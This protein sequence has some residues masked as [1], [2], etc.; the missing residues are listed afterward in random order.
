MGL[1][2]VFCA[3]FPLVAFGIHTAIPMP[4]LQS[5]PSDLLTANWV[6]TLNKTMGTGLCQE[7]THWRS[8]YNINASECAQLMDSLT[9][10]CTS[11]IMSTLPLTLTPAVA[12]LAGE[13]V[14]FCVG[15]LF[16]KLAQPKL[17]TT[18]ECQK[19]PLS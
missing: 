16:Y 7:G 19:K 9:K 6:L 11:R 12:S 10:G 18:P 2:F 1:F 17:K 8:C 15:E 3:S 13:Q 5:N 4:L 14:G